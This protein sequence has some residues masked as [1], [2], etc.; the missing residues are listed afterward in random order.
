M[1]C[2][3][4]GVASLARLI[5]HLTDPNRWGCSSE[6]SKSSFRVHGAIGFR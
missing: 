2:I 4:S 6:E 1:H 5:L 3:R